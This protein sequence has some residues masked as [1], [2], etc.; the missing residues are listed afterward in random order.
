MLLLLLLLHVLMMRSSHSHTTLVA[1]FVGR[2]NFLGTMRRSW[3]QRL[4]MRMS[5]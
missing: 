1:L 5:E 4:M 2:F 3:L